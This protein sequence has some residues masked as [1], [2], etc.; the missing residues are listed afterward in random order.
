MSTVRKIAAVHQN[1]NWKLLRN[2]QN[3]VTHKGVHDLVL[4]AIGGVCSAVLSWLEFAQSMRFC[5][6]LKLTLDCC[7][8]LS[9]DRKVR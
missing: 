3:K 5:T 4:I 8:S 7:V 9:Q 1:G 2:N 6:L